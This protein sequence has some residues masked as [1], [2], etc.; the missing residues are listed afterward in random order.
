[1]TSISRILVITLL[2]L[3]LLAGQAFA[4]SPQQTA[5]EGGK[6]IYGLTLS[7][8][9]IDPHVNASS[10]LGIPLTSVYDPLVWATHAGT[11]V[12]GLSESWDISPDGLAYTFHLRRDV[13]FH[14]G[15][16]FNAEAVKVNLE[17]IV[18]PETKSQKAAQMLGPYDHTEIV[19]EYTVRIVLQEP[20]APLMG[21]LS[22]V[23]VAMASPAA[24]E[25]WGVDY[26]MHQVG[27]G[28]FEFKEYVPGDH[29]TL[30]ANPDYDWAPELFTHQGRPYLDEIEFRFFTEPAV[31]ALALEDGEVQIMG[32][33]P[34]LDAQRLETNVN[35]RVLPIAIPGQTMHI[36]INTAKAPTD[37]LDVRRALLYATDRQTI[38][39][40][41]FDGFSPVAEGPLSA[42]TIGYDATIAGKYPF[43]PDKARRL[44]E[45]A[46]WTDQNGDGILEQDGRSLQLDTY[47]MTWGFI[48][49]IAVMLQAQFKDVGIDLKTETVT[50]PA[51]LD[52]AREGRHNLIPFNVS[53]P[54]PDIL[55]TFFSSANTPNGFNWSKIVDPELDRLLMDGARALDPDE[56]A[57][58]YAQVQQRIMDQALIIPIREYVNINAASARVNGLQYDVRGWFPLFYDVYLEP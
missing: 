21:A 49:E 24:L 37:D 13:R 12:P 53:D 6:L 48:P 11:F 51:A 39:D 43:D 4:A 55:R 22:Q 33:I 16:P 2:V 50:Y 15:T 19:D 31:R 46:G 38:V 56:R 34:P 7:P 28:P 26:Q 45:N 57:Q 5:Q 8:S 25:K 44:L 36:F 29:L 52:A 3:V 9:G 10:E 18:A 54:D 40:T 1:M 17:R 58:I 35:L 14:D 23:Y 30:V 41:L 20:F 32:E 47:L 42:G 27:T